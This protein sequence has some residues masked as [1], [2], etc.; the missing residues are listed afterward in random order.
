V[1]SNAFPPV[2]F[3]AAALDRHREKWREAPRGS[4]TDG[5]VFS[6]DLL[7]LSDDAFL[8]TW[9]GMAARRYTGEIGWLGAVYGDTF[10]GRRILELGS[11]LGFD[12]IRFAQLGAVWTFA[13]IVPDNLAVIRR[14]ADLKGLSSV[15]FHLIGDD[16][17]F[18][19]LPADFDAIWV[20][21]SI[22]HAPFEIARH[23]ALAAL[24]RLKPGGRWMELVYPRERWLREGALPFE[25]W[26]RLTD[27][28]RTPWV[29][30]YDIEKVRRRLFPAPFRTVLDFEFCSHNYRWF[31][32]EYA[33][34]RPFRLADFDVAALS[35]SCNLLDGPITIH[36][37]ASRRPAWTRDWSFACPSGLFDPA[38][39]VDLSVPLRRL[40]A[41]DGWA[42]D[43][44]IAISRGTIGAGLT[45][46]GGIYLPAA[47]AVI[48]AGPDTRLVSLRSVGASAPSSLVFRNLRAG[49]AGR[50]A[51]RSASLRVAN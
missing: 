38:V 26:G 16:L 29:E 12:G 17:S 6:S 15:T 25:E 7:A 40:G 20:F 9:D 22:H 49:D 27:G 13:D 31:D 18:A 32:L 23:E 39:T 51:V 42:V 1:S 5:R 36:T 41:A 10:R 35:R 43:L 50:F 30:W 2:N 8:A 19:A 45:G 48:D 3:A 21:G 37:G 44:E 4:D 28:D 47:E 33:A 14:V 11:G 34:E 24:E 46:V